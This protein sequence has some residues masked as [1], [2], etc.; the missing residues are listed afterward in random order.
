[1]K[2]RGIEIDSRAIASLISNKDSTERRRWLYAYVSSIMNTLL[3]EIGKLNLFGVA[4]MCM[5]NMLSGS[6]MHA[7][8]SNRLVTISSDN[9]LLPDPW[10][11]V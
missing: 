8:A 9:E 4:T 6:C 10:E 1:M 3:G 7:S 5:I 2:Q 11:M